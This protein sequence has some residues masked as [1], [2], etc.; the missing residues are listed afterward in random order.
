MKRIGEMVG[1]DG[2]LASIDSGPPW[3]S[4]QDVERFLNDCNEAGLLRTTGDEPRFEGI[5]G[6]GL[7]KLW[8]FVRDNKGKHPFEL[9]MIA[10]D[11]EIEA[12][13]RALRAHHEQERQ[14]AARAI[15]ERDGKAKRKASDDLLGYATERLA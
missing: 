15:A 1:I 7:L 4:Y 14:R 6:Y 3:Y 5:F 8:R 11:A 13:R 10:F 2:R 9:A 12:G